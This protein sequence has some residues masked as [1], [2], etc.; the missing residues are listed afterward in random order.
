MTESYYMWKLD[1]L[2]D[3]M[4][5]YPVL[6]NKCREY[7]SLQQR[8]SYLYFPTGNITTTIPKCTERNFGT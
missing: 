8:N 4:P 1:S 6:T 5:F 2:N 7:V 3:E